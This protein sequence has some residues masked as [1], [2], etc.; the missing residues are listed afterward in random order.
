MVSTAFFFV[1]P[2]GAA[3]DLLDGTLKLRCCTTP[4]AKRC[5]LRSRP[6]QGGW[7]GKRGEVASTGSRD[8]GSNGGKRVRLTR[9]TC[10]RSSDHVMLDNL[11]SFQNSRC[12]DG[13][14][15]EHIQNASRKPITTIPYWRLRK[16]TWVI[17]SCRRW[18]LRGSTVACLQKDRNISYKRG[19]SL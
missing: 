7:A 11:Q 18:F 9:K 17:K 10:P 8:V 5:P 14:D 15:D 16:N 6:G 3:A 19:H 12:F 13:A 4:F 2:A 1:I